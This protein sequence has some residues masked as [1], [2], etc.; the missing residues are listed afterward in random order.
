MRMR[1]HAMAEQVA[2]APQ[3]ERPR[4]SPRERSRAHYQPV[5]SS[6]IAWI[7]GLGDSDASAP[8]LYA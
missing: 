4:P 7:L 8:D 1:A 3:I 2:Q 5:I 6:K